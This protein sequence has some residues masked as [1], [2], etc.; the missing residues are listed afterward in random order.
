M[1]SST[2]LLL[3]L[4]TLL[5]DSS[6][7]KETRKCTHKEKPQDYQKNN[8]THSRTALLGNTSHTVIT[9]I[10]ALGVIGRHQRF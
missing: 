1:I 10:P 4:V 2:G 5:Y 9:E 6:A 3:F 7:N 8:V